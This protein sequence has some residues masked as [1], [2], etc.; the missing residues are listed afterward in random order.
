MI[1]LGG[2]GLAIFLVLLLLSKPSKTSADKILTGWMIIITIHLLSHY[3]KKVGMF[4]HLLAADFPL[5]LIHGPCLYLYTQALTTHTLSFK[6]SLLHFV[7]ALAV[8]LYLIPFFL[9]STAEKLY[10]FENK[11]K[12]YEVFSLVRIIAIYIS[13]I[14]YFSLSTFALRKYQRAI[15]DQF[16]DIERINLRWLQ[17]LIYWIG[18]IWL[19]VI[20]GNDD[21]IFLATVFFILFVGFFGIRQVGIFHAPLPERSAETGL[22]PIKPVINEGPV[23]TNTDSEGLSTEKRKYQ[24]SGLSVEAAEV[25]HHTMLEVMHREKLY[26]RSE[27]SLAELATRLQ[28]QPN[29]LS[30]VINEREG[31]NFFD[32]INTLRIEEFKRLAALPEN[33]KYTLMGLAQQCGFNSKS[34]FNRYFKKITGYSPSEYSLSDFPPQ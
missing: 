25:L 24:K 10:I 9:L 6:R 27:L 34:S 30:Q 26:C 32:F 23:F 16:S 4:P 2:V 3:F 5:P 20:L 19:L 8:V 7:P 11:G 1:Y 15:T 28:T 17:Y 29:Y 12:G 21:S 31:K 22:T 33:R 14:L 18:V 13:G